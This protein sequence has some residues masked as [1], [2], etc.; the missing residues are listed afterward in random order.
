MDNSTNN[1]GAPS[2]GTPS[3]PCGHSNRAK[4]Q[5]KRPL[6]WLKT[7]GS[8]NTTKPRRN[9]DI[10]MLGAHTHELHHR[11]G[12]RIDTV[13]TKQTTK[14]GKLHALGLYVLKREVQL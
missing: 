3:T 6:G 14:C 13:R 8:I 11:F 9:L 7:Y 2:D 10:P 12:Q 5:H 4:N 1:K